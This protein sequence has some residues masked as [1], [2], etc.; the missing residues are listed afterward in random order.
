MD[1][2]PETLVDEA[3]ATFLQGAVSI[4]VGACDRSLRP[5]LVRA[6]GCRISADRRR[7]TVF[8]SASQS[9]VVLDCV[10]SKGAIAVVFNQ[11]S[12]HRTFQLKSQSAEIGFL[13]EGDLEIMANY[14]KAFAREVGPLGF[15][16]SLIQA[17][18]SFSPD[19]VVSL[20]FYPAEVFSQTP[21]PNAGARLKANQ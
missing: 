19:D 11:P 9:A 3:L 12:T 18:F 20:S 1:S 7:V 6:A 13:E 14:S 4:T 16:E 17:L 2:T 8:V 21:G 5:C 10:R 15:A